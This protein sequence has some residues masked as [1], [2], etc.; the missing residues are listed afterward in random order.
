MLYSVKFKIHMTTA[1]GVTHLLEPSMHK[2]WILIQEPRKPVWWYTI[3]IP[4]GR[5]NWEFMVVDGY[6]VSLGLVAWAPV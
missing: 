5:Q 4:K 6:I 3:A 2:A 1:R